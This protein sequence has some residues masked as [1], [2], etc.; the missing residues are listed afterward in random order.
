MISLAP[1]FRVAKSLAAREKNLSAAIG[2][3][4]RTSTTLRRRFEPAAL[5]PRSG[6]M[7]LA[8]SF[9]AGFS[10]HQTFPSR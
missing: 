3:G 10:E 9:K 4:K 1:I 5:S 8:R 2:S 7:N 6:L